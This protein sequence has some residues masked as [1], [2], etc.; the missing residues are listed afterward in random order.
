MST[1][2]RKDLSAQEHPE[3]PECRL[4]SIEADESEVDSEFCGTDFLSAGEERGNEELTIARAETRAVR[5]LK[6]L[7]LLVL[8]V[9]AVAVALGEKVLENLLDALE[10][11]SLTKKFHLQL[12]ISTPAQ[13][14]RASLRLPSKTP[15]KRFWTPLE[16]RSNE[17]WVPLIRMLTC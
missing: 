6:V 15:P 1:M 4:R 14:N 10:L 13:V 17:P 11:K 12:S 2:A 5:S 9:S 7:V 16:R 3:P 8:V